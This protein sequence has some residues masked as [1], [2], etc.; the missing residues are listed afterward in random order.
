M[1]TLCESTC[2]YRPRKIAKR[3]R[4]IPM[5][6]VCNAPRFSLA[7]FVMGRDVSESLMVARVIELLNE[8]KQAQNTDP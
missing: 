1:I 5:G 7:E 8:K 3:Y 2:T 6:R 4:S